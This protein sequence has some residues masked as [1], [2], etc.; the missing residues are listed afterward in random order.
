M[1]KKSSN[2]NTDKVISSVALCAVG[3]CFVVWAD[4]VTEWL[5][6]FLG[7]VALIYAL[8]GLFR[9]LRADPEVR[10]TLSL[11]YVILSF[12]AGILLVSRASFIKEAI[13]FIIGIYIIL[14]S[15]VQLLNLT[16][17]RRK[18]GVKFGSVLWPAI[19]IVV[20]LL[21][22]TGQFIIPNE[23]ARLTGIVMI[24]YSIVYITGILSAKV[25][26]KEV[27][28]TRRIKEGEIVEDKTAKKSTGKK[29]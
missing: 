21:C 11:F 19:G 2:N 14:T 27:D 25:V 5:A 12:A 17:A 16:D 8:V 1:A 3:I 10:T 6:V 9:F 13:S 28:P 15:S 18:L 20:G 23:L 22:V 7:V 29:K 26:E 24:I 4:E